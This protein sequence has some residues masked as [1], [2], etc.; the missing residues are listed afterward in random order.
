MLSARQVSSLH[1]GGASGNH[2]V[3]ELLLEARAAPNVQDVDGWTPLHFA[4]RTNNVEA[5][6]RP[7]R[8]S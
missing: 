4:A 2:A 1:N 5:R 7:A 6:A 3:I 8:C